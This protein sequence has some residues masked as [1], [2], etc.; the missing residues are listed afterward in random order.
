MDH[1]ILLMELEEAFERLCW[2]LNA[3]ELMAMGLEDI[4]D[5]Y[6]DGLYAV[7]RYLDEAGE[8]VRR[9]FASVSTAV[10]TA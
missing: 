2:G 9:L 6:A 1:S 7:W 8:E 4:R 5:P 3:V 10:T